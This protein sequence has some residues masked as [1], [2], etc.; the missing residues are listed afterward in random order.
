MPDLDDRHWLQ[1]AIDLSRHCPPTTTAFCVGA[2][3]VS[4]TA[5]ILSTGYSRET[6]PHD[7][8][9]EVAL[10]KLTPNDPCLATATIY[11]SLEPCSKRASRPQTCTQ[12]ILAAG[13]PRVVLAWREPTIFV[14]CEGAE[15][16]EAAGVEVLELPDL[17]DQVKQINANV[18]G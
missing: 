12:L 9:E 10:A 18:L 7:H 15:L 4:P 1:Q 16:L 5:E 2:I 13:I 14:D 3:I 6:H 17:A 11:T 8:A